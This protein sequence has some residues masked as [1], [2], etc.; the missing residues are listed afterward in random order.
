MPAYQDTC[1]CGGAKDTRSKRC[2][3]C[4]C[5]PAIPDF[6]T[7]TGPCKRKLPIDAFGLRMKLGRAGK[8]RRSRCKDCELQA[9]HARGKTRPEKIRAA[10]WKR[11][12]VNIEEAERIFQAHGGLCDICRKPDNGRV[13]SLDH[14]HKTGQIRGLLCGSCNRALGLFSDDPTLLQSAIRYLKRR[15]KG[16]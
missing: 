9:E 10:K 15:N 13:L 8:V 4:F 14:D 16:E 12:G 3:H 6:K 11:L 7:C 1:E 5:T 2:R